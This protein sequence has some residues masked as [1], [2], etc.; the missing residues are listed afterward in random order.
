MTTGLTY[1]TYVTQLAELA[2]VPMPSTPTNPVTTADSNFNSIIPAALVYAEQRIC[3]DV[4]LTSTVIST[5]KLLSANTSSYS[6][7]MVVGSGS[8]YFTTIQNINVITPSTVTFPD[9][10]TR[11]PLLPVT[12]EFM[13]YA[14]PSSSGANV[15]QYFSIQGGDLATEGQTS[16]IINIGPWPDQ[17]Y[18]AEIIGTIRPTTLY[19]TTNGDNT[20]FISQYMP[21]LLLMAS[22]IYVSGYQ[23]NFGRQSDDPQTAQSYESQYQALLKGA[24]VEEFRKKFQAAAW[25]S[26]PPSPIATPTR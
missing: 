13:Q 11:N 23:R 14:W 8:A 7:P 15:P 22:M 1:N 25:S 16:I 9:S 26:V 4:D 17:S 10:G 20:T 2:V 24:M 12:K 19:S 18:T 5:T 21:D 3:R 6:L